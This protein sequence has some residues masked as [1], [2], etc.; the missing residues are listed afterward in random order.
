[1]Q[2]KYTEKKNYESNSGG[3][4]VQPTRKTHFRNGFNCDGNRARVKVLFPS[5]SSFASFDC[6][7]LDST[8]DLSCRRTRFESSLNWGNDVRFLRRPRGRLHCY[9]LRHC[10]FLLFQEIKFMWV[11]ASPALA[12]ENA[13]RPGMNMCEER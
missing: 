8:V 10:I 6:I 7:I 3:R 2:N 12:R 11:N 4:N 5:F 9:Q 13:Q 1:M